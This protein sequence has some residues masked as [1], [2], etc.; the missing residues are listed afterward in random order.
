MKAII[1]TGTDVAALS[2]FDPASLDPTVDEQIRKDTVGTLAKLQSTKKLVEIRT[3]SD[4]GYNVHIYIDED[5]PSELAKNAQDPI[6]ITDFNVPSGM[7]YACGSEYVSSDPKGSLRTFEHMG[8]FA[9]LPSGRYDLT[10]FRT[11]WPDD[12]I[13]NEI[14]KL[15]GKPG[16]LHKVLHRFAATLLGLGIFILFITFLDWR[17]S[18]MYG[19][20]ISA[21]LIGVA[22]G[23]WNLPMF[24]RARKARHEVESKYEEENYPSVIVTMRTRKLA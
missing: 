23:M 7:L 16:I 8:G 6:E 10:L 20:P 19:P 15:V 12:Q 5:M 17:N 24:R 11:E 13:E 3:G 9:Q 4:G 1:P 2:L 18:Y 22:I 21:G 14:T